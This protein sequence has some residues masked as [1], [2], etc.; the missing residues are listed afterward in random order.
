ME[1]MMSLIYLNANDA[2]LAAENRLRDTML[3]ERVSKYLGDIWPEG[4]DRVDE[5]A[6]VFAL[7]MA[8]GSEMELEFLRQSTA[9]GFKPVLAT[10]LQTEFVTA[11]SGLVDCYRAPLKLA[12]G[13]Q[14]REWVVPLSDRSGILGS[15]S[16]IYPGLDIVQYWDG[17]REVVL[18][19][20]LQTPLNIVDFSEWYCTQAKRFGWQGERSKSGYYYRA[21]MG[22]Y[23]SGRAI[24][25]D[26]PATRFADNIMEPA[27]NYAKNALG[28]EAL[29]T[30]EL[31]SGKRDWVDMSFLDEKVC[32]NLR[33]QGKIR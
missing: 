17:I 31:T 4:F 21:L 19:E 11:N 27:A 25:F 5:P 7:Y 30:C 13:Q 8:R 6:A 10:Y 26:T 1:N 2:Y 14:S 23:A 32:L 15:A 3:Q 16:T 33:Q 29:I 9:T 12:K 24:L 22:L 20:K 28:V 18:E